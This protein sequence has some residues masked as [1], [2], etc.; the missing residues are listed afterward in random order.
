VGPEE[1]RIA[2]HPENAERV[3]V[4]IG[5]GIGGFEI[6]EREHQTL[7]EHGPAAFPRS[8]FRP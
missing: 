8:S 5:S 1:F 6:M 4:Y 2:D 7:L 3:G